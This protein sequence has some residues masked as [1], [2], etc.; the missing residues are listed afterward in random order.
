MASLVTTRSK[1]GR[2]G[3]HRGVVHQLEGARR[4]AGQRAEEPGDLAELVKT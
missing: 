2:C 4:A 3:H 1:P